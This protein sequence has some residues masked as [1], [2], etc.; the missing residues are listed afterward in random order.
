MTNQMQMNKVRGVVL[1]CLLGAVGVAGCGAAAAEDVAYEDSYGSDYYYPADVAY[2]GV[3]AGYGAGY[4]LYFAVPTGVKAATAADGG[5]PTSGTTTVR[6]A[7]AQAIR[8][9][10]MGISVCGSQAVV[11]NHTGAL[12]CG[13]GSAGAQ[14]VFSGCQLSSGG[15][16]D[17]TVDVQLTR[18]ASDAN[19]DGSTNISL[20]YSA[21]IT[22]LVYTAAGGGKVVIPSQTSTA[23]INYPFQK[24]PTGFAVTTTG[25][26][27]R[28]ASGGTM[29]SDRN[30][31]GTQ[32]Y[33]GVSLAD[34][35]Y[36]VGGT[37]NVQDQS[38]GSAVLMGMGLTRADGCCKPTGGTL[39]VTR[40]GGRSPDSTPGPSRARAGRRRWTERR[41]RCRPASNGTLRVP[42]A[43]QGVC[44]TAGDGRG[45][46]CGWDPAQQ[47][48]RE[49]D[50]QQPDHDRRCGANM[51]EDQILQHAVQH[52]GDAERDDGVP[53]ALS[54]DGPSAATAGDDAREER[55]LAMLGVAQ[56][57][58]DTQNH[59]DQRLKDQPN[60]KPAA[61]NPR[62]VRSRAIPSKKPTCVI[63][64]FPL[65]DQ[66]GAV[67]RGGQPRQLDGGAQSVA[68]LPTG[69]RLCGAGS[70]WEQER[71]LTAQLPV[72]AVGPFHD[73]VIGGQPRGDRERRAIGRLWPGRRP[74]APPRRRQP[75]CSTP[76]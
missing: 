23:T 41:S 45:S 4:G 30:Y 39:S 73:V 69:P 76:R 31:T 36:T 62:P 58:P 2:G 46:T 13:N 32:T 35:T 1:G 17:G 33:S 64:S 60:L 28:F 21:T 50:Q 11:T 6:G 19:C 10:M 25:E 26:V 49:E 51:A 43:T 40:T 74:R 38:G 47:D 70:L 27:Q 61:Q 63:V 52:E 14:I 24:T 22:N 67:G 71:D 65:G 44:G 7:V 66:L 8:Q 34:G 20:G 29:T 48:E 5:A 68:G 57:Q 75:H 59:R 72:G 42:H 16:I 54:Q 18:S 55:R 9:T 56:A 15:M 37:M 12:V 3:Y 53:Q